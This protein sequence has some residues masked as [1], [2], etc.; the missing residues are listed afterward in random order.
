MLKVFTKCVHGLHKVCICFFT[1]I[2]RCDLSVP[3]AVSLIQM[4]IFDLAKY[5]RENQGYKYIL[6][7]VDVFSGKVW[8]YKMKNRHNINVFDSFKQFIKDSNIERY[9]PHRFIKYKPMIFD[10]DMFWLTV[11]CTNN[12]FMLYSILIYIYYN[13]YF[14]FL[15]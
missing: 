3:D 2:K 13:T 8:A 6:C 7:I 5:Y 14:N 4:D 11:D 12:L 1:L 15:I 9:K 10:V